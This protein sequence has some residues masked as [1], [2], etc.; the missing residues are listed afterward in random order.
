M[1]GGKGGRTPRG[2]A[3]QNVPYFQILA[4]IFRK[5]FE[6][7]WIFFPLIT[8]DS[9]LITLEMVIIINIISIINKLTQILSIEQVV[10]EYN[11]YQKAF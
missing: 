6:I 11:N 8:F 5:L 10:V 9:E 4:L 3:P 2:E 7:E 1:D